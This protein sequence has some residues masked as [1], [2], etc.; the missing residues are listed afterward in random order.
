MH[1]LLTLTAFLAVAALP[2]SANDV[3]WSIGGSTSVQLGDPVDWQASVQVTG[4]NQ[5]LAGYAFHVVIGPSPGATAGGDG[6][7]GTADDENLADVQ[8]S[9]A[10]FDEIFQVTGSSPPPGSVDDLT[11]GGGPGM[12]ILPQAG[13]NNLSNGQLLQVGASFLDWVAADQSAGVGQDGA[14]A[15]LLS[16]PGADYVLH[17]GTIP[18]TGL[19]GGTYTVTLIPLVARTLVT[20]L[21]FS[22]DQVGFIS[23]DAGSLGASFEV[24][25]IAPDVPGDFDDDGDVDNDDVAVFT[26]CTTGPTILYDAQNL[27]GGCTLVP[28][29][30]LIEA[31]FDG[32]GDVSQLDFATFQ[33]CISGENVPGDP[34]CAD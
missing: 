9:Q 34:N 20:D 5:G 13:T 10:S 4:A 33:K 25:V 23:Q 12:N 6:I 28:D 27:P 3:L 8:L 26:A 24:T 17:S 32:N 21:D 11:A 2:A 30:G 19:S 15:D 14:K 22:Q 7:W 1:R 16:N 29:G 31:D 18:T